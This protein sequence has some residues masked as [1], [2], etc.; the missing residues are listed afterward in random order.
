MRKLV[1]ELLQPTVQ[2]S[3]EDRELLYNSRK[4]IMNH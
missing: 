1:Y 2:R 3:H 4:T